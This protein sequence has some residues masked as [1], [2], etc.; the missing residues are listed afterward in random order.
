[1]RYLKFIIGLV[2]ALTLF[3][4]GEESDPGKDPVEEIEQWLVAEYSFESS[5][6]YDDSFNEVELDVLFLHE[7]GAEYFIPAF[8]D[9]DSTWRV[10]FAPP[11]Q[12]SWTYNTRCSDTENDGLH[13]LTGEFRCVSYTGEHLIY[14]KGF[15]RA[16]PGNRYFTY[17]DG[18]P[19]F[20]LGD[21]HANIPANRLENFKT[22]IDKR[23]EQGFTV[24]QSQPL[25]AGYDLSNGLTENDL[26]YFSNL[27]E[28]FKYVADRGLVH[29]NAQFFFVST[30]GWN[31]ANYP[32]AYLEKLARY[33]VARYSAYPVLWTTAQECDNDFNFAEHQHDYYTAETNPWKRVASYMHQYDPYKHPLTAHM[34]YAGYTLAST[35][36][37]R[38]VEGHNWWAVQW[39]PRKDGVMY[40]EVPRNFKEKGQGKVTILFEGSF[41]YLWTN[42]FGA[43]MQGWSAYL[44]GMYGYGYGAADIWLYN[45]TYNMD[46]PT[47][48][49]G[50]TVTI[51][52]KQTK[53]PESMEFETAY[54]LGYMKD[55]F[56]DIPWWEL[57]PRFDSQQ[58]LYNMGSYYALASIA[59]ELYVVYFYNRD[60]NTGRIRN[61]NNTSYTVQWFNPRTG[62][63]ISSETVTIRDGTY[64]IGDKPDENDW[65]LLMKK[66]N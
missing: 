6:D 33:W 54:Q 5:L 51:E 11:L 64:Q 47:I 66:A 55:F 25:E 17:D 16:L 34:E 23:V 4:C 27:D 13:G 24:I 30:L 52:Q 19:F 45:S 38:E 65:V 44:N 57:F 50:I 41:D 63:Y 15:I 21:T 9:G 32:D 37:F 62:L 59:S 60:L 7:E 43:R 49:D 1:M 35:S 29:A 22:I 3:A 46:A 53:W 58:W 42:H 8:W 56:Q 2:F 61:L 36:S 28:R 20:Y 10:R 14:Q 26:S 40:S 39:S 31:R 18:T 48:R 12:G